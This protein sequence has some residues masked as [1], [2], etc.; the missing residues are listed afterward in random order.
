M[1]GCFPLA[2]APLPQRCGCPTSARFSW[3]RVFAPVLKTEKQNPTRPVLHPREDC[4]AVSSTLTV[5][6][7][8]D[9]P[10]LPARGAPHTPA[11]P[12]PGCTPSAPCSPEVGLEGSGTIWPRSRNPAESSSDRAE[13]GGTHPSHLS[14]PGP[15]SWGEESSGPRASDSMLRMERVRLPPGC[16]C[17]RGRRCVST[18]TDLTVKAER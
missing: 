18:A 13:Q 15:T 14:C 1:M 7:K 10:C 11:P 3:H 9:G 2:F 6:G 5:R 4:G 12:S 17:T 8:T 16:G